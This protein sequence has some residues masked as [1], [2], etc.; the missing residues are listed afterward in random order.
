MRC[1]GLIYASRGSGVAPGE[2][3]NLTFAQ[4]SAAALKLLDQ[5]P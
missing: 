1:P 5:E 2:L 4:A 3:R